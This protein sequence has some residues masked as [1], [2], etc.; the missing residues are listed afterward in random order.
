MGRKVTMS[1]HP[2]LGW[3]G[4]KII[5]YWKRRQG[6]IR[7]GGPCMMEIGARG[8][9]GMV[10]AIGLNWPHRRRTLFNNSFSSCHDSSLTPST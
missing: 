10:D 7:S 2:D 6:K 8:R 1:R 3:T 4:E 5:C 9:S